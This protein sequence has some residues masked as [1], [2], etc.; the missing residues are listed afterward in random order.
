MSTTIYTSERKS[1][2][3]DL[4]TKDN[5]FLSRVKECTL[6][7]KE[8][9]SKRT[10]HISLDI[11]NS[12][13]TYSE[14][15]AIGILP[16]NPECMI[17][18]LLDILGTS[19]EDFIQDPRSSNLI[20]LKNYL[21]YKTNLARVT[22]ALLSLLKNNPFSIKASLL[23]TLLV[24]ENKALRSEYIEI[25]DVLSCLQDFS[26]KDLDLQ[27]FVNALPPM[28]PRFYSIASSQSCY[29]D[30]I[31][32]LVA[33]FSYEI[34]GEARTGIGSDFLCYQ[35]TYD[36]AIPLYVQHNPNF[37]LPS[38]LTIPIIMIGP[39]TGI[40]P[41][42]GFLQKRA[43]STTK[44]QNW[45]FFGECHKAY[46]FY[47]EQEFQHYAEQG[48]L[49]ISTAFSRDQEHKIY[50]QHQM[51]HHAKELW[52]WINQNAVL[53]LCGDA[54]EMAKDVTEM[55]LK[56]FQREGNLSLERSKELLQLMRK[57]KRFQTDVY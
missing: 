23:E 9:S 32:L 38:D 31:H 2:E 26:P 56:I 19:G 12:S 54:K 47:Y 35:A 40:A 5:P 52:Q 48:L 3:K 28:L 24:A 36:T 14:G 27:S 30:E 37:T 39:G 8:G 1:K 13:I 29:P 16:K 57:Q 43:L 51:E 55:L 33:T 25:H 46:D 21:Y 41:Y 20:S 11:S 15:D 4:F 17:S 6:L 22:P 18:S 49:R 50:V 7:N 53:Y 42:R 44:T 45:L 34:Q 10:F